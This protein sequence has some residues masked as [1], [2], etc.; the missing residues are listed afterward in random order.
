MPI[1]SVWVCSLSFKLNLMSPWERALIRQEKPINC[2]FCLLETNLVQK[3][4]NKQ[5]QKLYRKA[6]AKLLLGKH[7]INLKG[8]QSHPNT[9]N[10]L[11]CIFLGNSPGIPGERGVS[12]IFGG[13]RSPKCSCDSIFQGGTIQ[14][15]ETFPREFSTRFKSQNM[16][17]HFFLQNQY[18][19][20]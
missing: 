13:T 9:T 14:S 17:R 3:N 19:M 8:Q 6:S 18:L 5:V 12:A 7:Q 15:H 1:C 2:L 4:K 11:G 20:A 10:I 16:T